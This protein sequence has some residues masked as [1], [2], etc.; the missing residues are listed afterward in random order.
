M[1]ASGEGGPV[2]VA[3]ARRAVEAYLE[4]L[5]SVDQALEM[6]DV[7][8]Q[9][10]WADAEVSPEESAAIDEIGAMVAG[11]ASHSNAEGRFEV[12]IVPQTPEQVARVEAFSLP[13]PARQERG[14]MV[15]PV[16]RFFSLEYAEK[17]CER[18]VDQGLF[19]TC[20]DRGAESV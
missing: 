7:L 11:Y 15:H 16:G 9:I 8:E 13:Q 10:V 14:G 2:D 17:I 12:V 1:P 4:T 5:P 20:L 6:L 18:Y 3:T 19:T